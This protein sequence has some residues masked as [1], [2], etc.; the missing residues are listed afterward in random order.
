MKILLYTPQYVPHYNAGDSLMAHAIMKHLAQRNDVVV[1][2]PHEQQEYTHQ[3]VRVIGRMSS[4]FRWADAVFCHLDTTKEAIQAA[5]GKPTFWIQHNTFPYP[6]VANSHVNVIYNAIHA[7]IAMR[8]NN[9]G[10]ILTPPVDFDYYSGSTGE[11]VTIINCNENKGGKIVHE[12]ARRM[13]DIQFLMVLGSYGTQYVAG[14][15]TGVIPNIDNKAVVEGLGELPNV[16]VRPNQ[17]DIRVVYRETKI[18]LMP[19][20]YESWGRT[21]TEAVCSGIPVI[22]TNTPGLRENCGESGIFVLRDNIDGWCMEI[23]KLQGKQEYVNAS[24][25]AKKRAKEHRPKL[26]ALELWIKKK[27]HGIQPDSGLHEHRD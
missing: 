26:D 20:A 17:P 14:P 13:P 4:M 23:R 18:L 2:L 11:Y 8:W 22:C 5:K 1:M 27:V 25:K 3:G 16:T 10:F 7:K 15:K 19:S 9:D 21:A 12:I 6:S 24:V